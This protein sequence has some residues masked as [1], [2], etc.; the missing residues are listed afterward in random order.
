MIEHQRPVPDHLLPYVDNLRKVRKVKA[1]TIMGEI[2]EF[3]KLAH[4]VKPT[5]KPKPKA[6]ESEVEEPGI[7]KEYE[8][9]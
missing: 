5:S 3:H 7:V 4:E 2:V 9:F 8:D 6:K 1:I